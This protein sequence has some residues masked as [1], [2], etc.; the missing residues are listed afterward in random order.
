MKNQG[1]KIIYD[2]ARNYRGN[3]NSYMLYASSLNGKFK[4][5]V[6]NFS[7]INQ[8]VIEYTFKKRK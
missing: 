2:K 5:F 1:S 3:H 4:Y 7:C 8:Y 6:P